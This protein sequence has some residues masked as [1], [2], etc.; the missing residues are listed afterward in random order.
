MEPKKEY[1]RISI[2]AGELAGDAEAREDVEL[3]IRESWMIRAMIV[4]RMR[5]GMTQ[6]EIARR[7]GCSPSRI[8][9]IESGTDHS[10][11]WVEVYRYFGALGLNVSVMLDQPSVPLAAKIKHHV[12]AIDEQLKELTRLAGQ[13]ESDSTIREGI[14]RF[15]KEVLFNFLARFKGQYDE[16]TSVVKMPNLFDEFKTNEPE[17][18]RAMMTIKKEAVHLSEIPRTQIQSDLTAASPRNRRR[19]L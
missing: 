2:L 8:S 15:Y 16:F 14:A 3:L 6:R 19:K 12:F 10:L 17:E 11:G 7:M 5:A 1:D 13:T 18:E 4:H 9:K